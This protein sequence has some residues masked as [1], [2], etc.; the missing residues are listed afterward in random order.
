MLTG[1]GRI[2]VGIDG[3]VTT[4]MRFNVPMVTVT[5][6]EPT[7]LDRLA[8]ALTDAFHDDPVSRW[9]VPP[10]DFDR[11]NRR[12]FQFMLQ[13]A[14][15][16][17]HVRQ[18]VDTDGRCQGAAIWSAPGEWKV[19]A[20]F[21]VRHGAGIIRAAGTRVLR[22]M[23]R[24]STMERLHPAEPPHWY[25]ACI[26]VRA[27]AHGQGFGS[28]LLS[29]G[30]DRYDASGLPVYLESSNRRNLTLYQRHGFTVT[31]EPTFRRGPR[32]WLLWRDAPRQPDG[33]GPS[34][35]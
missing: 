8:D 19:P 18:L 27:E 3:G 32:Q 7:D 25:L 11:R 12:I 24:L 30:L 16:T 31:G 21:M 5:R 17:G 29:E 23:S 13:H 4:V 22:P 15:P 26:G 34:S 2:T 10:D 35:R 28:L 6:A 1:R 9:M 20:R 33:P 14:L